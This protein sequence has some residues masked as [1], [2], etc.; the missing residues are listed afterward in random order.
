MAGAGRGVSRRTVLKGAGALGLVWVAS[1]GRAGAAVAVPVSDGTPRFLDEGEL[2]TLRALVDRFVPGPPED[3]DPGAV[4]AGCAEAIDALLAAFAVDP[5]RIYAG[6]PFSDRAGSEINHFARFVPLDDYEATA[7]RLR[8]EGSAGRPELEFNGPVRGFQATYREGLAALDAAAGGDFA[9][10]PA[11]ARELL[12]RTTRDAA[13]LDLI[14]VAFP[15]TLEFL[16][17]APEYGGN[18]DLVGWRMTGYD[19]DVQPRGWTRQEVENA[20]TAGPGALLDELGLGVDDLLTVAPLVTTEQAAGMLTRS[21][22]TLRGLQAEAAAARRATAEAARRRSALGR[23]VS[24]VAR[25][26]GGDDRG[27]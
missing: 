27:R 21:G 11:P 20:D 6:G 25:S 12:L 24:E 19:G 8:I 3:P 16:Y 7:W 14:D 23:A 9:A 10:L 4:E 22:G 26:A 13:V 1:F 15:H 5:P 18:R 2:A 17:G